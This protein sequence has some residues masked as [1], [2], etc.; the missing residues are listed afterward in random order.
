MPDFGDDKNHM[1]GNSFHIKE[2]TEDVSFRVDELNNAIILDNKKV[3]AQFKTKDFRDKIAPLIVASGHAEV[4]LNEIE[5]Q[6]GIS[7]ENTVLPSGHIV[8]QIRTIDVKCKINRKDLKLHLHGNFLT[9]VASLFEV[10]FKGTVCGK[11]E[12]TIN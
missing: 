3:T 4:D 8:P 11:I 6:V 7:F 12:S 2:G 5:I 1:R 10:F 9:D